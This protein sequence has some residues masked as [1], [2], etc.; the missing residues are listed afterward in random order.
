M[1]KRLG[2]ASIAI[3]SVAAFFWLLSAQEAP[4]DFNKDVRPIFNSKCISC[5]GG[6]KRSGD[7][8]LLF[9]SEALKPAESGLMAIVPGQPDSSELLNRLIHSDPEMRMPLDADPLTEEEVKLLRK[10]IKQGAKWADHWA[11]I[12]PNPESQVP[13]VDDSWIKNDMD[14]FVLEKLTEME[15]SPSAPADK[16]TILR[17]ASLDLTGLPPT[18]EELE[19]FLADESAE[20]YERMLD[21]LLASP[22][23]GER[24]TAMWLDLARYGDSQGYQKD[25]ARNIWRY[26]DW[27]IDA[28]NEDKPFDE[29]TLEQLAGDLLPKPD[30]QQL[31]ATAF[32]RNTMSNDEGGTDDEEFRVAAVLDRVNT[33][34]EIWQGISIACVQCHTHPYDPFK[35]KEFYE[36]YAFFNNSADRD[37]SND[38]PVI[39][40]QSAAQ[41]REAEKLKKWLENHEDLTEDSAAY[42][43]FQKKMAVLRRGK[44]PVMQELKGE[45]SR[46]TRVF[47]RGNWLVHGD[48]V[49]PGVPA[50]LNSFPEN[51]P[52]N[53]LGLAQWLTDPGNP[54][55]ARVTVN[56]FW[57]QLFGIGLVETLEDFG[58]EGAEVVNQELLDYLAMKFVH[59]YDWSV[60]KLLKH[61]MMSASYRQSSKVTPQL[62]EIDPANRYLARGPRIR[63]SAEQIR[64][65][66]LAVSGLLSR[67]M[68]GPSVM[69]P[70]PEGV[71]Q[72]IR[73]VLR[74]VPSEGEDRYRRAL[75]TFWRKSSPY[76]SLIAFD[77][78][79]KEYCVSRRIRTN[80]P[81]QALVTL[82]DSTYLEAAQALAMQ[83]E[84]KGGNDKSSQIKYGYKAALMREPEVGK[85]A[86]LEKFYAETLTFYQEN[87]EE[88]ALFLQEKEGE[89]KPERAALIHVANVIL[90]L[91]E[92]ITK[93]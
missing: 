75:Y 72:V 90:N 78:P 23:Y 69:P 62:V 27:V 53:R 8:S 39:K 20:A 6:V 66:A 2:I 52:A 22:H 1:N 38:F 43:D 81:I 18:L 17:R 93:E 35:H 19:A 14:R 13:D 31:L 49:K 32:H 83:M 10:W 61:I 15:L 11:F 36:L 12:P 16:A 55:T 4:V 57:E 46:T 76:P 60:K 71:W 3:V 67:K 74:W 84:V 41:I 48:T 87:P 63:L 64:D 9:R 42:Q 73:N 25:R 7:F 92:L 51:A 30:T 26:R 85:Q 44:T 86:S 56:R 68:H 70:Q 79:S 34:F 24:W 45:D 59:E 29:F 28:F 82:N 80:T 50:V 37:L 65:Q 54:L 89:Q 40:L 88:R 58:T 91:D 21:K 47:E 77:T 33:T 5:H